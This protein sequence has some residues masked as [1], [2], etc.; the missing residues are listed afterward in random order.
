MCAQ[1]TGTPASPRPRTYVP[2][3]LLQQVPLLLTAI[4]LVALELVHAVPSLPALGILERR[5]H[6][7]G[8]GKGPQILG[9]I[10]P[11][12]VP[13]PGGLGLGESRDLERCQVLA[14]F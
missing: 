13:V 11:E 5:D 4:L 3:T 14:L 12:P 10:L 6:T 1:H 7:S 9:S 8:A 2:V